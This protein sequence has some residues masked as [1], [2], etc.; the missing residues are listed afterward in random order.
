[1]LKKYLELSDRDH[2][3]FGFGL[4]FGTFIAYLPFLVSLNI[5]NN[6]NFFEKK[7]N[8][9]R[10]SK[11]FNGNKNIFY[12][13]ENVDYIITDS[14]KNFINDLKNNEPIYLYFSINHCDLVQIQMICDIILNYKGITNAIILKKSI[15]LGVL[16]I[17][18]CSNIYMHDNAHLL[19][20]NIKKNIELGVDFNCDIIFCE[21]FKKILITQSIDDDLKTILWSNMFLDEKKSYFTILSV[22]NL[23]SYGLKIN[24]LTDEM[25]RMAKL[26]E[27]DPHK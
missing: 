27:S 1:M 25:I 3:S 22:N 4:L 12:F 21:L 16:P 23:K 14:F 5:K 17:L 6:I 8:L 15:D 13:G 9:I 20:V 18:C 2:K 26:Y 11:Y 10:K 24:S 7:I 19:P